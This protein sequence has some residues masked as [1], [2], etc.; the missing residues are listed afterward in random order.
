MSKKSRFSTRALACLICLSLVLGLNPATALAT[1]GNPSGADPEASFA[2]PDNAGSAENESNDLPDQDDDGIGEK[3]SAD[4]DTG[5]TEGTGD[6]DGTDLTGTESERNADEA[7]TDTAQAAATPAEQSAE[8]AAARAGEENTAVATVNYTTQMYSMFAPLAPQYGVTVAGNLA[9]SYGYTDAVEGG[10]SVLDVLVAAHEAAMGE[11]F[12][13]ETA[14]M[15]LDCADSGFV[16]TIFGDANSATGF[17]YN[18]SYPGGNNG[19]TVTTQPVYSG[20]TIDFFFYQDTEYYMDFMTWFCEDGVY[21]SSVM[22]NGKDPLELSVAGYM[23]AYSY[24]FDSAAAL[25]GSGNEIEGARLGWIDLA[26]GA[27]SGIKGAITDETGKVT[28]A[29]PQ[30][31]GVYY[32]TAFYTD[33]DIA[34]IGYP[35]IMSLLKVVVDAEYTA[36]KNMNALTNLEVASFQSNPNPLPLSPVFESTVFQYTTPEVAYEDFTFFRSFYVR[37]TA[38]DPSAKIVAVLNNGD[39]VALNSG[40]TMWSGFFGDKGLKPGKNKLV[41]T[42]T[43]QG[44][45]LEY[46]VN[47]SMFDPNAPVDPEPLEPVPPLEDISQIIDTTGGYISS[48]VANPTFSSTGGEW[49]VIGQTRGKFDAA[50]TYAKTYAKNLADEL[51]RTNGVLSKSSYTDYARAILALTSAGYDVTDFAGYDLL[52]PL[53]DMNAVCKQGV[54][55]PIW[56]LIAFDSHAYDI[57]HAMNPDAAQTT[58]EALV[59][60]IASAQFEDGG[61]AV[62]G[63]ML[64]V[65]TTAMALLA[66]APYAKSNTQAEVA[67]TAALTGLEKYFADDNHA[68]VIAALGPDS[69]AQLIVALTAC[70]IDPATDVRFGVGGVSP[71]GKLLEFAAD[72]GTFSRTVGGEANQR[73]TEQALLSLVAYRQFINGEQGL[74][75]MSD[76]AIDKSFTA[77]E[78]PNEPTGPNEPNDPNKPEQPTAPNVPEGSRAP[79]GATT[80][81]PTPQVLAQVPTTTSDNASAN[82]EEVLTSAKTPLAYGADSA[83]A[84]AGSIVEQTWS[85]MLLAG[86]GLIVLGCIGALALMFSRKKRAVK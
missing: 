48:T 37:A 59:D 73:A 60:A 77:P 36:D 15:F 53:A 55:G 28:L 20:D 16:T 24:I 11:E 78:K 31:N 14:R 29:P 39:P 70:N 1:E 41:V 43:N 83:E 68:G 51:V 81:L 67:I 66:L 22:S 52:A 18:G 13:P 86:I 79:Q 76:V 82:G 49:A 56:A 10:V 27:I 4:T 42:V 38:L 33:E 2:L 6:T 12:T 65:D 75:N 69:Y 23:Y 7:D 45:T 9:E 30:D 25:H 54:N 3:G 64:D 71:V 5:M 17:I 46:V 57:P 26:S 74:Y 80:V 47:V 34:D 44:E 61:W 85:P 8:E 62:A 40:D 35:I 21:T 72:D 63:K 32:L 58:R 50:D 84:A 19:T